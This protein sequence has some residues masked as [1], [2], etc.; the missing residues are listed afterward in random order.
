MI[1]RFHPVRVVFGE[2][3]R[4]PAVEGRRPSRQQVDVFADQVMKAIADLMSAG[5][6]EASRDSGL[7]TT[8]S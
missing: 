5:T 6:P 4:F 7:R 3:I 8:S 1:P 2:Q